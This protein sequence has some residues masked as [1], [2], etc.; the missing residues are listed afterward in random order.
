M[1]VQIGGYRGWP[2]LPGDRVRIW[3]VCWILAPLTTYFLTPEH[4]PPVSCLL[5]HALLL[6][7][8][9]LGHKASSYCLSLF[10]TSQ[11]KEK[12]R[13]TIIYTALHSLEEWQFKNVENKN[14]FLMAHPTS[15]HQF[16]KNDV[17]FLH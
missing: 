11:D 10:P 7:K 17:T 3:Y 5:L 4:L 12:R 1:T 9:L 2:R 14:F 8:S 15:T 16:L 13:E 6:F